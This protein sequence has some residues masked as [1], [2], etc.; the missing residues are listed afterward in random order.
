MPVLGLAAGCEAWVLD[1]CVC[2]PRLITTMPIDFLNLELLGSV[3]ESGCGLWPFLCPASS[4]HMHTSMCCLAGA[5]VAYCEPVALCGLAAIVTSGLRYVA[6][7]CAIQYTRLAQWRHS[8]C[9]L[10]RVVLQADQDIQGRSEACQLLAS[11]SDD[12]SGAGR[13]D[14]MQPACCAVAEC[15]A[16]TVHNFQQLRLQ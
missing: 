4:A 6:Q 5:A 14:P 13:S 9:P 8:G 12:S 7:P 10:C 15:H 1:S 2:V 3:F 16:K 11:Q